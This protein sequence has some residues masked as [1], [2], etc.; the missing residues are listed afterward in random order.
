MLLVAVLSLGFY[1]W[2]VRAGYRSAYLN[3]CHEDD[4]AVVSP[5]A[6][7]GAPV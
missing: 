5:E 7:A 6:V 1:Y 3:E 2:G 4:D